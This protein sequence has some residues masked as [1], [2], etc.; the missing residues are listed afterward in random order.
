M[1]HPCC[2]FARL[3]QK[4]ERLFTL[5]V[6]SQ[7]LGS[8]AQ[9]LD[10]IGG[11]RRP[12]ECQAQENGRKRASFARDQRLRRRTQA[13]PTTPRPRSHAV[14]GSGSGNKVVYAPPT[15]NWGSTCTV[16]SPS[17][18]ERSSGYLTA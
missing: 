3:A 10:L 13:S 9:H 2:G 11:V 1:M 14:P 18:Y 6:R 12:A 16:V 17:V 15:L 5:A 8:Q 4:G 7:L